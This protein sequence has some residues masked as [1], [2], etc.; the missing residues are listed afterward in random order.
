MISV[1]DLR[2]GTTFAE[3]GQLLQVLSYEHIKMGR[4]SANIK[5]KVRNIKSGSTTEK[6]FINGAVVQEASLD[7]RDYQFL[8]KDHENASFMDPVSFEQIEIPIKS[9]PGHVYLKDGET[10]TIQFYEDDPIDLVLPP[11]VTLKVFET[12]P[13]VRGDSASNVTKDAEL[14][15]GMHVRVPLFINEGDSVI[16][17]T[18]DGTYTKRA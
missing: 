1:T 8:Y 5:V 6:S 9:L 3:N 12:A 14:A 16:V 4:G 17:D 13:G 18:R 7:K 15:N 2:A 11:K 10:V